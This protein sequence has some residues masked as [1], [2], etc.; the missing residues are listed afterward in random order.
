MA[1]FSRVGIVMVMWEGTEVVVSRCL[2][3]LMLRAVYI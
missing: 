1:G 3:R 2:P